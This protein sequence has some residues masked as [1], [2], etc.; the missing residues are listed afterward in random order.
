MAVKTGTLPVGVKINGT[1]YRDFV[2]REQ[3]V[4]DEIEILED[5]G[6]D[7][8]RAAKSD[9][10]FNVCVTA[11]RLSF[12]GLEDSTVITPAVVMAMETVDFSHLMKV[13]KAQ[14]TQRASFR[15]AAE[16]APDAAP[17]APEVRVHGLGNIANADE[18]GPSMVAGEPRADQP[19]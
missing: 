3:I 2:L 10:F 13:D 11:K 5:E 12:A 15:D 8:A 14:L 7:A 9:A 19:A 6:P 1:L 18:R 16:A 17:A 4:A